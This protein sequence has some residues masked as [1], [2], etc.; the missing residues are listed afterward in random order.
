MFCPT[1]I[2]HAG[3]PILNIII[4][5]NHLNITISVDKFKLQPVLVFLTTYVLFISLL[6]ACLFLYLLQWLMYVCRIVVASLCPIVPNVLRWKHGCCWKQLFFVFILSKEN[7][8]L[9]LCFIRDGCKLFL[10]QNEN[11]PTEVWV[12]CLQNTNKGYFI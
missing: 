8:I 10:W 4:K 5:Y 1:V 9:A 11:E 12:L 7:V 2:F 6:K 3:K